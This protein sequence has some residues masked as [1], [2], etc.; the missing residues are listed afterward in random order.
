MITFVWIL[1]LM[2]AAGTFIGLLMTT[3][4]HAGW[5]ATVAGALILSTGWP[6]FY[7]AKIT[8]KLITS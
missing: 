4:S 6:M 8:H 5:M 7:S 2:I 1:Y 3:R